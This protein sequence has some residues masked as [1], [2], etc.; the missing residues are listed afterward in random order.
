MADHLPKTDANDLLF[1]LDASR[2]YDPSPRLE[3]IQAPLLAR[4]FAD[5]ADLLPEE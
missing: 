2:D 5:D 4:N 3:K 1:A